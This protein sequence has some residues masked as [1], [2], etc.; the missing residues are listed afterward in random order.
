MTELESI[1]D[2]IFK[3]P[4]DYHPLDIFQQIMS[5]ILKLNIKAKAK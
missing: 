5:H 3:L 2:G 1:N 4:T